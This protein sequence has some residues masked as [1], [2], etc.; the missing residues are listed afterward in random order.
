MKAIDMEAFY[1]NRDQLIDALEVGQI[2]KATYFEDSLA[3]LKAIGFKPGKI[4]NQDF[5]HAVVHY[6]YYNLMA[7]FH[8]MEEEIKCF[9]QPKA[10]QKHHDMGHDFYIK[11]DQTTMRLLELCDY[12][13]IKAYY[14]Q[15][16]SKALEGSLFEVVFLDESRIVLHSRD[17]RILYRLT[18]A[19]VFSDQ[20]QES[21]IH[22]Y[23]NTRYK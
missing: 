10:A 23:V 13:G 12:K 7:K 22:E 3:Y 19:G 14:I 15:M 11:K 16:Q 8:F 18:S 6:Q 17:K 9:N 4:E 1:K 20:I 2:D 5:D 21:T